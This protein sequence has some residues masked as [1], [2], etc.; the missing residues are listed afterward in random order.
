ML[1]VPLFVFFFKLLKFFKIQIKIETYPIN[2]IARMSDV[3]FRIKFKYPIDRT[4]FFDLVVIS[5]TLRKKDIII[6]YV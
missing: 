2:D 4:K 1:K 3:C 6:K 5:I